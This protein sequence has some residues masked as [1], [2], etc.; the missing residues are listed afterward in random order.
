MHNWQGLSRLHEIKSPF[1]FMDNLRGRPYTLNPPS[2]SWLA[3]SRGM[4]VRRREWRCGLSGGDYGSV[5]AAA[6][7]GM[8]RWR[9]LGV[10]RRWR[11]LGVWRRVRSRN[12]RRGLDSRRG[13]GVRRRRGLSVR[14]RLRG[15]W[16]CGVGSGGSRRAAAAVVWWCR[17]IWWC[18]NFFQQRFGL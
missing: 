7:P 10:R 11:G 4:E 13:L 3:S 5:T 15:F 9:G 1:N 14:R 18:G 17:G 8:W 6:G 12:W 2:G 16:A